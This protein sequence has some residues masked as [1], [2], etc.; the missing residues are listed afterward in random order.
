MII[1]WKVNDCKSVKRDR[2][3]LEK[4]YLDKIYNL[5]NEINNEKMH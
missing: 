4:S 5:T 2:V 1:R 3:F